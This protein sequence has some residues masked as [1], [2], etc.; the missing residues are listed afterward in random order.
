MELIRIS[1]HKL[2]IMLTPSDMQH[3]ELNAATFGEDRAEMHRTFRLLLEEIRKQTDF[4]AEENRISVQYFPSREGGCEMF[5][6][7]LGAAEDRPGLPAARK[8][9]RQLRTAVSAGYTR[10]CVY[11]FPRIE[12]LLAV[13]KRLDTL[14]YTGDSSAMRDT[15]GAYYLFL[16][17]CAPSPFSIPDELAFLTEYGSIESCSIQKTH[18]CEHGHGIVLGD[19]VHRL[20]ELA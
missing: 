1:D 8:S 16:T 17:V 19:A 10:E 18:L 5:I 3:F 14:G 2:K 9:A 13:C 11:R 4:D 20:A 15:Q 7:R 6:S 12:E